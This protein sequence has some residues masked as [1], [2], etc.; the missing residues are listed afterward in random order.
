MN[1]TKE[2]IVEDIKQALIDLEISEEELYD[3]HN[4]ISEYWPKLD[5]VVSQVMWHWV[6]VVDD[7]NEYYLQYQVSVY[8]NE[9]YITFVTDNSFEKESIESLEELADIIINNE[10]KAQEFISIIK[11]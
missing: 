7:W 1:Y 8:I 2:K 6:I 10:T 11:K 4:Y 5:Q 9:K 3:S